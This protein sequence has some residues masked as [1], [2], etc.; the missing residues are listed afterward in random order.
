M[1]AFAQVSQYRGLRSNY[2]GTLDCLTTHFEHIFGEPRGPGHDRSKIA[3]RVACKLCTRPDQ[4]HVE[5]HP[6]ERAMEWID[7]Q[8]TLNS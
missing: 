7:G 1:H 6:A 4:P 5:T 8:T 2:P 3:V